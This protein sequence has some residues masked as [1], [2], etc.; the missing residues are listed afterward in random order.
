MWRRQWTPGGRIGIPKLRRQMCLAFFMTGLKVFSKCFVPDTPP[1]SAAGS[2]P[3][4]RPVSTT[5]SQEDI[6]IP[7]SEENSPE[8]PPTVN[9]PP[10][11]SHIQAAL[12]AGG[13]KR[14][15]VSQPPPKHGIINL[16]LTRERKMEARQYKIGSSLPTNA[17]HFEA[18]HRVWGFILRC[19]V[20]KRRV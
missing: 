9:K 19:L 6:N 18:S 20:F 14:K 10:A 8:G 16:F 12:A 13:K 4:R 7:Q 15:E 2:I 11:D 1:A 3:K 5:I 17:V